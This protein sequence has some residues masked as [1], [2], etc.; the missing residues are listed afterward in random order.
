MYLGRFCFAL[1]ILPVLVFG[2]P[3]TIVHPD[4]LKCALPTVGI[5]FSHVEKPSVFPRGD[6]EIIDFG[7]DGLPDQSVTVYLDKDSIRVFNRNFPFDE[8]HLFP[9]QLAGRNYTLRLRFNKVYHHF[10]DEYKAAHDGT[11][12]AEIPE[13]FEMA[14]ILLML[15]PGG[16]KAGNMVRSGRYHDEVMA[17]FKPF[18]GHPVFKA[19]DFPQGRY[20]HSYYEFRENS[21][22]FNFNGDR[23]VPSEYFFVYGS[24]DSSYAN[25]FRNH[26]ALIEDFARESKFREFYQAH[27]PFYR[28]QIA[29][30]TEWTDAGGMRK[31]LERQFPRRKFQS[32]KV[33]FSPVILSSHST[34]QFHS[35][36]RGVHY[37][38]M[39]MF[40]GGPRI[41]DSEQGLSAT[42]KRGLI[43]GM[44][45]T[46]ADHNYVN[47]RSSDYEEAVDSIFS[48][49]GF[50][51]AQSE[52]AFYGSPMAVFNEYMTHALFSLYAREVYDPPT[53]TFLIARREALM[54]EKRGFIRFAEFNAALI[55]LKK[56]NADTTVSAL[57]P[58][59]IDWCRSFAK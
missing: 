36:S 37:A 21:I 8:K 17:H 5:R 53:A 23:L 31:W 19:L 6:Y 38:E 7:S 32:A 26:T 52:S 24:D 1:W 15:A 28:Q 9:L 3:K 27:L 45:F 50:W 2:Q 51:T 13:T 56:E 33:I 29:L 44:V 10:S 22:C 25:G 54:S 48:R 42:Q 59:I 58:K 34:Q 39:L 14:N 30:Q 46:E 4:T 57:Y 12:M 40:V 43:A 55:K 47:G 18:L 20:M 41:Y 35:S 11:T 49:R 16:A